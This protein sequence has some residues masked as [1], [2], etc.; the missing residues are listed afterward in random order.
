MTLFAVDPGVHHCGVAHFN[1][2]RLVWAGLVRN[3]RRVDED[4]AGGWRAMAQEVLWGQN[5]TPD[6]LAIEIPKVYQGAKQ[7]GDPADLLA[8]ASVVGAV[9]GIAKCYVA[10][11]RP[12]EWKRQLDK[13][14]VRVRVLKRLSDSERLAIQHA[15]AKDHNTYDA[16]GIGL[17]HLGRFEPERVYPR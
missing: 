11:Y 9:A 10:L 7:K 5:V 12:H 6:V 17:K 15:G 4:E 16:I 2:G 8:L 3:P 14:A 13:N 1:D